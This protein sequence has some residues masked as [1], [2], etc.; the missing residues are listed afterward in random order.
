[1]TVFERTTLPNGVRVLSAPMAHLQ[2]TAVYVMFNAGARFETPETNGVAHFV[3]HM[4]FCGT[5]RRPSV[6]ALTGEVD[7]I[8]GLFNAGTAKEYTFYYVK[9]ASQYATQAVDVLADMIGNSLFDEGE[10]EREKKVIIEELR[11][12]LDAPRDYVDENLERLVYAGSSLGPLK[13]GTFETISAVGR[14]TLVEWAERHYEPSRTVVGI[15]GRVDDAVVEAV[16]ELFRDLDGTRAPDPEPFTASNG[17]R[18]LLETKPI[19]QAH[20]CVGVR[21]Y[22]L[23]H[24]DRYVV[25]LLSTVLGGGMSSRLT[26]ELTMRRGLAYTVYSV[27]HSHSDAGLLYA[28]GG[29]NVDKVDEAITTIVDEFRKIA[30]EP[31]GAAEL[32]KARN[33][34]KGRFVFGIETPQGIINNGLRGEVLEGGAREPADVLADFDAVTVDDLQRVARDV[35]SDG[36]YVSLIGPF[37]DA[38]HVESLI[39]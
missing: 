5:P 22:P 3:E 17:S 20:L 32:E 33:Y 2:S 19:D 13:I 31:V 25:H 27:S 35:L 15:A 7:A 30:D 28:Q 1:V 14:D 37:D 6:R 8:G 38:A 11:A 4:L 24:P 23:T 16:G 34:A 21:A 18:V 9:C 29:F 12:K 39:T 26:E 36:F 10:I